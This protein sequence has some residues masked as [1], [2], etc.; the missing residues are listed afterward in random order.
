MWTLLLALCAIATPGR[1]SLHVESYRMHGPGE[2]QPS[3]YNATYYKLNVCGT[4]EKDYQ[5]R[6]RK[7]E[8][9]SGSR[10]RAQSAQRIQRRLA[11]I[12]WPECKESWLF[13][14]LRLWSMQAQPAL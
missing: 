1:R 9:L 5:C 2:Q 11:E 14:A 6:P 10:V 4:L 12:R 7:L 13:R 3:Q 8:R